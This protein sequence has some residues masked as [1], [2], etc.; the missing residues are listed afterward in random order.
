MPPVKRRGL[1]PAYKQALTRSKLVMSFDY[2]FGRG[3]SKKLDFEKFDFQYSRRTGRLRYVVDRLSKDI[4]FTLRPNGSIAPT[5][6]GAR[7]MLGKRVSTRSR[8]RWVVTVIDGVSEFVASGKTVFC[9]HVATCSKDLLAGEDVVILNQK[10]D[11]LAVGKSVVP[12]SVMKQFK[13][14]VAVKVREGIR[15]NG[16]STVA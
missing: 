10:G 8:P 1:S 13:K 6:L 2:I 14:G 5:I 11:L 12:A 3:T 16:S 4:L 7:N 15:R 9:R